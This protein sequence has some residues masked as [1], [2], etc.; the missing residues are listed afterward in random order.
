MLVPVSVT[1]F[2]KITEITIKTVQWIKS[3]ICKKKES[4][5]AKNLD[6]SQVTAIFLKQNRADIFAQV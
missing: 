5:Y 4:K 3:R 6:K 2:K 1:P